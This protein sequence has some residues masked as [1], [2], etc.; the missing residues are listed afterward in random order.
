MLLFGFEEAEAAGIAI[1]GRAAKGVVD[2]FKESAGGR[3]MREEAELVLFV[4][5]GEDIPMNVWA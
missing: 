1:E 2:W 3:D 5:A 4:R